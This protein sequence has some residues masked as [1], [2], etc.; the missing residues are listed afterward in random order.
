MESKAGKING[1]GLHSPI[2]VGVQILDQSK[3]DVVPIGADEDVG[4]DSKRKLPHLPQQLHRPLHR[5]HITQ[6][7]RRNFFDERD[8]RRQGLVA[9]D[10]SGGEA[11]EPLVL[12]IG[13]AVERLLAGECHGGDWVPQLEALVVREHLPACLWTAHYYARTPKKM[14]PVHSRPTVSVRITQQVTNQTIRIRVSHIC[15]RISMK[16]YIYLPGNEVIDEG[17]RVRFEGFE[18]GRHV[19]EE[20]PTHVSRWERELGVSESC[21]IVPFCHS[22]HNSKYNTISISTQ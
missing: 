8:V 7:F 20:G 16:V 6:Q 3:V 2:Q 1:R 15:V 14:R 12:H 17:I 18:E 4:D 22:L 9:G 13:D 10:W 19:S 5:T 11:A 21:N